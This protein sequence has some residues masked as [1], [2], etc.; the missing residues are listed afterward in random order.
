MNVEELNRGQLTFLKQNYY[1]QK[2]DEKNKGVSYGELA[3]I[4]DLVSDE[5]IY[6]KYSGTYFV[7]EDFGIE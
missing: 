1:T 6:E 4:D 5:E 7:E 2:Q 3:N